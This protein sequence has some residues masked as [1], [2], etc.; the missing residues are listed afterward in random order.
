MS[1]PVSSFTIHNSSNVSMTL[2][3]EPECFEHELPPGEEAIIEFD[4]GKDGIYLRWYGTEKGS[5]TVAIMG[6]NSLY[7]IYCQGVNVFEKY[8]G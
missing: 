4:S 3:H 6:D 1:A 5:T 7:S 2:I 8:L